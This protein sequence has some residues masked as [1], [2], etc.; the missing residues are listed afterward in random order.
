MTVL[1]DAVLGPVVAWAGWGLARLI[2]DSYRTGK[3]E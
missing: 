1:A 3:G 2:R